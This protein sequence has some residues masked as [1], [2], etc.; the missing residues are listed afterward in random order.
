[1]RESSTYQAILNEGKA[2]GLAEGRQ[3]GRLHE[4]RG[5]LVRLGSKRFG[6]PSEWLV[7]QVEA[8]ND[9]EVIEGWIER[10]VEATSWDDLLSSP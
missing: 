6:A 8:M 4:A 2:V 10:I 7:R 3:E 9:T 5:L 1:M